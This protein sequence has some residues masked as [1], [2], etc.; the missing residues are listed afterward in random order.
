MSD[1]GRYDVVTV[2]SATEDIMI[3]V[4]SARVITI[5]DEN[6]AQS[7]MAFEY[8]GKLHV[9]HILVSVGGGA[10][11]TAITFATQGM[12]CAVLSK[13][14]DDDGAD[15]VRRRLQEAGART[16]LL[17]VSADHSTGYSTIITAYTGERTVLVHRGASRELHEEDIDWDALARTE[18]L[19]VAALAG[20]SW[21]L[22]SALAEFALAHDIKLALNLGTSQLDQGIE[23]FADILKCAHVLF[24]NVQETRRLTRVPPERGDRDERE[25]MRMLHDVGV[26]IV[27]VTD[28][29]RGAAAWDGR[30]YYTVPAYSVDAVCN[31]G[32]G[33]AF[34]SG[35][36]SALHRGLNLQESLRMGA[37]NSA[38]V[39]CERGANRGIL[40]WE[41]A[42]EFVRAH[43]PQ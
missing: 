9:D 24:Q 19:Y 4:N 28:G 3:D 22:Y 2:G 11:N 39:V 40:T 26:D 33:D 34:A 27:V 23:G 16:E 21:R 10:V 37:A 18:W 14:G 13:V 32:A 8:G 1:I 12:T 41:Q 25:M 42:L 30:A 38:A 36:V 15:R 29:P 17:A 7:Y 35:C 5:E 6:N 20:D 43:S 31:L